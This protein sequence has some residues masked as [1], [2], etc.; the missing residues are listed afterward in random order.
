MLHNL[1]AILMVISM[2]MDIQEILG[3]FA[4]REMVRPKSLNAKYFC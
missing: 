3:R 1:L 4:G 2:E